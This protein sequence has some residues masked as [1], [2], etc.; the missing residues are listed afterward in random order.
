VKLFRADFTDGE[1][2]VISCNR[3]FD[4]EDHWENCGLPFELV[5]ELQEMLAAAK[6][7]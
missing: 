1:A 5:P 4:A 7:D 2:L 3:K 6:F